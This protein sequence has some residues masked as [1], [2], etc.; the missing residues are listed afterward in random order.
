MRTTNEEGPARRA[1]VLLVDDEESILYAMREYLE[2][3]GYEVDCAREKREAEALLAGVRYGAVILD[4]QLSVP[5]GAEGLDMIRAIRERWPSSRVMVL[6]AHG[7]PDIE[8]E[9]RRRGASAFMAKPV[10][11]REVAKA[12]SG[13]LTGCA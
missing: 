12:L 10:P 3:H 1:R 9:A 6:T 2:A 7:S 11:M 13:I 8:R 5:D 4:L